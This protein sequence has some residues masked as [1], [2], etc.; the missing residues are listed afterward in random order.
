VQRLMLT[1]R[2]GTALALPPMGCTGFLSESDAG[3]EVVA[4]WES[5]RTSNIEPHGKLAIALVW[6]SPAVPQQL[7]PLQERNVFPHQLVDGG[8]NRNDYNIRDRGRR[9]GHSDRARHTSRQLCYPASGRS[10][11]PRCP[12]DHSGCFVSNS[13]T[14]RRLSVGPSIPMQK[15]W[16][17]LRLTNLFVFGK[18]LWPASWDPKAGLPT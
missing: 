12:D 2:C 14:A 10:R 4:D 16:V 3:R 15:V 7:E 6:V 8:R 5:I 18:R 17:T 9:L 1:R 13:E 11:P